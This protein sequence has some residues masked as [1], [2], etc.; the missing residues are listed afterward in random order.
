MPLRLIISNNIR[1]QLLYYFV[2]YQQIVMPHFSFDDQSIQDSKPSAA[3][4]TPSTGKTAKKNKLNKI[5]RHC[6]QPS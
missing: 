3:T 6:H 2:R 1:Y 4:V 5:C